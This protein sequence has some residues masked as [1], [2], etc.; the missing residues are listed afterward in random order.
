[1]TM[2]IN[3]VCNRNAESGTKCLKMTTPK[4]SLLDTAT[5]TYFSLIKQIHIPHSIGLCVT[6]TVAQFLPSTYLRHFC[7]QNQS[8]VPL[9]CMSGSLKFMNCCKSFQS[10]HGQPWPRKGESWFSS[11]SDFLQKCLK[12]L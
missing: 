4:Y 6:S 10:K 3:T 12:M 2:T 8:L 5:Q 9:I 1:M 11:M 7:K